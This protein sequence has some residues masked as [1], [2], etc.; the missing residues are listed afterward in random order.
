[1][2]AGEDHILLLAVP[3]SGKTT[4][5]TTRIAR[6]MEEGV[7]PERIL[8]LT[9]SRDTAQD[10]KRRYQALFGGRFPESAPAFSTIH[11]FCFSVLS[12]Y[13]KALR[14]TM[15]QLI[16]RTPG[17]RLRILRDVARQETGAYPP[18]DA[19]EEL[20]R[21]LSRV[22]NA[23]LPPEKEEIPS[24]PEIYRSY[25]ARKRAQGLMDFDDMLSLALEVLRRFPAIEDR[26]QRRYS[27]IHVDEAQD[28]SPLQHRILERLTA[29]SVFMVGDED[30]SI[31]SFRG[32][33]PEELLSFQERYPG[34]R[35][36]KLEENFR[37]GPEL[38]ER[39]DRFIRQN[40]QRYEK[41]M[42]SASSRETRVE[43]L[44]L[45]DCA[46]QYA[47]AL[48][49]LREL[50]EGKTAAVLYRNNE[51][52]VPLLEL[53]RREGVECAMG[54]RL[55]AFF[56]SGPIRDLSAYLLLAGDPRDLDA[57]GQ[58]YYKLGYSRGI[59]EHVKERIREYDSVFDCVLGISSLS[60]YRKGHTRR[61]RD[62]FAAL[63]RMK[64]PEAVDFILEELNYGDFLENRVPAASA[65]LS[66]RLKL[67]AAR[68]VGQ[69]LGSVYML[70]DRLEELEKA[71]R[72]RE[73]IR[74]GAPVTLSTIHSSKGMEFD[75]VILVDLLEGLF[76][77]SP[78]AD[79]KKLGD[80]QE[81]ENEVRLFY[82]GA[83]RARERLILCR[84]KR[85]G[86]IDTPPSP[87][88]RDF[89]EGPADR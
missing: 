49:L 1:M 13:A 54:E 48:E 50:P 53:F 60:A 42:R 37:S 81:Y 9:F 38:V 41:R 51:S 76:P 31:Y 19:L 40:R 25:E 57:F 64:P 26:F 17:F 14:R 59:F 65:R 29:A 56:T 58:I 3:G 67:S 33:R 69:G 84:P 45:E 6:L 75:W 55:P 89:L 80:R 44:P 78:A 5:L 83:T 22:K 23:M 70:L 88:L 11:S 18:D 68:C 10:M 46:Q 34:A 15:P 77:S 52:A 71:V 28:T 7:P 39:A 73:G 61:Y 87:F 16:E 2:L 72:E 36:L 8:T 63:F 24:F 30:Q 12:C 35:V 21:A 79:G 62:G 32:A 85:M 4:V 66:A 27:H 82:V 47:Q 43:V 86:G 20:E 74:P